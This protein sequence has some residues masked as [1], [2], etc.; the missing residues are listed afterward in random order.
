MKEKT[1]WNKLKDFK[2]PKCKSEL[3]H[4]PNNLD[5]FCGNC[6]FKI[7][8]EKFDTIINNRNVPHPVYSMIDEEERN[9]E[10]LNNM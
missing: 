4:L 5:Y 3:K 1:N 10:R 9:Q 7:S 8:K 6:H 2:C